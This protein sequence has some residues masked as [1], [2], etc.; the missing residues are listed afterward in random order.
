MNIIWK[1]KKERCVS[2][3]QD[4]IPTNDSAQKMVGPKE[5]EN[6][7]EENLA[8]LLGVETDRGK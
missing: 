3:P 1:K 6:G 5:R 4:E 8:I 7:G 2:A